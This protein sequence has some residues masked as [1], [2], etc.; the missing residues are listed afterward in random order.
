VGGDVYYCRKEASTKKLIENRRVTPISIASLDKMYK[1]KVQ[2]DKAHEGNNR[3]LKH[4]LPTDYG[5]W[6]EI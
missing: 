2:S 3:Y 1:D 5:E 4:D 6:S